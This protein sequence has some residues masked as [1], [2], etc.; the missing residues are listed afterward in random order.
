MSRLFERVSIFLIG[1]YVGLWFVTMP[2]HDLSAKLEY[3]GAPTF[4]TQEIV[5]V[6]AAVTIR[7]NWMVAAMA[8]AIICWV[9]AIILNRRGR[10]NG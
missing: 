3:V 1:A 4:S 2:L 10:V 8:G 9:A 7:G 5:G 6:L